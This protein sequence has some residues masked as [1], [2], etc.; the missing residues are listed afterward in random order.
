MI[1]HARHLA[2]GLGL[3]LAAAACVPVAPA[4]PLPPTVFVYGDSLAYESVAP[5]AARMGGTGLAVTQHVYGGVA[6]CDWVPRM[7][8]DLAQADARAVVLQ[9]T[10]NNFTGCMGGVGDIP[11]KYA[12]DLHTAFDQLAGRVDLA[13]VFV[14]AA[15]PSQVSDG[16]AFNAALQAVTTSRGGTWVSATRVALTDAG[17]FAWDLPCL[18]DEDLARGC[19][20]DGRIVVRSPDGG[21]FCPVKEPYTCPPVYSS[22]ARRFGEAMADA[23]RATLGI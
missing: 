1:R 13:H 22:G 8:S 21:H 15:P 23:V 6:L 2:I 10:G 18:P 3:V 5:F 4:P 16:V 12:A 19:R 20:V 7:H 9:F 11:A 17:A 14:V